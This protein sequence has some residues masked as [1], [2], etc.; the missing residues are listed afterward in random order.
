MEAPDPLVFE[1]NMKENWKRWRQ[2]FEI[3]LVATSF[4]EKEEK[5]QVAILLHLIGDEALEVFNTFDLDD[6]KKKQMKEVMKAF[7][8]FFTL[9]Y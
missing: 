2:K 9:F 8:D 7:E 6:A 3:Y 1:G 4:D 5:R